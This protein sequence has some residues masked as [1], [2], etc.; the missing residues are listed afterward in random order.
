MQT[1]VIDGETYYVIKDIYDFV[2]FINKTNSADHGTG[3]DEFDANA[4]V[5]PGTVLDSV[6]LAL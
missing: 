6:S 5:E 4:Y 1:T 3:E 2:A